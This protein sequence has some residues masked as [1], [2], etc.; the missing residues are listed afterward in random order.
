MNVHYLLMIMNVH[1][2]AF[3]TGRRT[4]HHIAESGTTVNTL[5]RPKLALILSLCSAL[6]ACAT[7]EPV[8]YAEIA[9]SP[10]LKPDT[11][12]ATGRVPYRYTTEVNWKKYRNAIIDPVTIYRGSDQQFGDMSE[13][14]RTALAT[15]MREKFQEAIGTRFHLTDR[16]GPNTLRFRLTLTGAVRNIRGLS[17]LSRFDVAG[18]IYNSVRAAQNKEGAMMGAVTY[19][20]EIYD[21][22]T[23]RLLGA[24]I[25]KQYPG[26]MNIAASV[27]PLDAAKVGIDKGA[28]ALL[29]QLN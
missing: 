4:Q 17:T 16:R 3:R 15:H 1:Y 8:M 12:D 18:A 19:A 5:S 25:S 29:A 20:V 9:S 27:E 23:S 6:A 22:S 26:A 2:H 21:D 11:Q 14:D 7:V 28:E 13:S 24:Y 10:Y